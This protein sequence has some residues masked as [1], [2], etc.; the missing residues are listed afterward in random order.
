MPQVLEIENK[1][2]ENNATFA[3]MFR[4]GG[5]EAI[6]EYS[7]RAKQENITPE[8]ALRCALSQGIT[9]EQV[10]Q[11]NKIEQEQTKENINKGE[12]IDDK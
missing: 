2:L 12:S 7:A 9:T 4:R 6:R 8:N 10:N 3:E 5:A 1:F 11:A